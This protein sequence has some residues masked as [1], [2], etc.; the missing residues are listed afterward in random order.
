MVST[1]GLEPTAAKVHAI[2]ALAAPTNTK[3][4]SERMGLLNYYRHFIP[5]FAAIAQ[6]IY[7]LQRAGVKWE[8]GS[9]QQEAW[10]RLKQS[11][12]R[13]GLA[14]R[15]PDPSRPF[16]LHTDWS[17][18][19]VGAVLGQLDGDRQEYMVACASRSLNHHESNY[20][21]WKGELLAVMFGTKTFRVYLLGVLFTIVTDH[22]PL[23]W[24]MTQ[25]EATGQLYRWILAL[26][27]Y[28]F[29]IVYRQG[30]KHQ[31]ADTL[32]RNPI[33]T[34]VDASGARLD[35]DDQA[36]PGR[37]LA[38]AP[39]VGA[40]AVELQPW[41]VPTTL[42]ELRAAMQQPCPFMTAAAV[43]AAA[44]GPSVAP[45]SVAAPLH[46]SLSGTDRHEDSTCEELAALGG[47]TLA[48]SSLLQ[49]Q[50]LQCDLASLS[51]RQGLLS[52]RSASLLSAAATS[53]VVTAFSRAPLPP[54]PAVPPPSAAGL[55][56]SVVAPTF[57]PSS[58]QGVMLLELFGGAATG[59]E[60]V[61]R[62]GLRVSH[63]L[64]V[65]ISDTARCVARYRIQGLQQLYPTLL[66]PSALHH[67]F[68]ALPQDVY[69]LASDSSSL[70]HQL[71]THP[72]QWL[73]VGGW[74]CQDL[75]AAGSGGTY[76]PLL[77]I[78]KT[79]QV[80]AARL[81]LPP[82]A[83]VL[84]NTA[85]QYNWRSTE[86]AQGDYQRVCG[87]LGEPMVLDAAQFGSYAHRLRNFWTNLLGQ[88]D[89]KALVAVIPRAPR[90]C[91]ADI[92]EPGREAAPVV[93]DDQ[94]P[95]FP[96]NRRGQPRAALPTIMAYHGTRSARPGQPGSVFDHNTGQWDELRA[97]ER[98]RALGHLP[99]STAAPG[100]TELQR[101]EVLG[102]SIDLS[103]L[104]HLCAL[105]SAVQCCRARL[106]PRCCPEPGPSH[107]IQPA[108]QVT[109]SC[110]VASGL[111]AAPAADDH[112][113]VV[114]LT[115]L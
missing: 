105:A 62:S 8:W 26:G 32:S 85:F 100:I 18:Q 7:Q 51:P 25:K 69:H 64:Y 65:D 99:G 76:F 75:S 93:R 92:L 42:D 111:A 78:L 58:T 49:L 55:D 24:M 31:N 20:E 41:Q 109:S 37:S 91:V 60:A 33:I 16:V 104:S 13:P 95:F 74:E 45:G 44:K 1:S 38:V 89:M 110:G 90:L 96:C 80:T 10:E 107:D 29:D 46:G 14:L 108:E 47:R 5:G 22:R 94:P 66:P 106:Q 102:R 27:E 3:E 50:Q 114:M 72:G 103:T 30:A 56:L 71:A 28:R 70:T 101:R 36:I 19:G 88:A 61:L 87:D 57:F 35:F 86:V 63:Y 113:L 43:T 11:L 17:Q 39:W 81:D 59:L 83:Y 112:E 68:S 54:L 77:Q 2:A 67:A 97:V 82:P 52:L 6:P 23:L 115:A 9:A 48:L 73:V 34:A 21:P 84:E 15:R 4:I 98:E 40:D 12:C 53:Y 79:L